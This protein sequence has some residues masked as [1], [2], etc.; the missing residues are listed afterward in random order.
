MASSNRS[1][2]YG[3]LHRALKRAGYEKITTDPELPVIEHVLFAACL[4]N[5]TYDAARGAYAALEF[6]FIDWNEVRV[7]TARELTD[8]LSD[9]PRAEETADR[10]RKVLQ[11]TFESAYSFDLEGMRKMNQGA[12][13]DQL[14]K[15]EGHTPFILSYVTQTALGGHSIPIDDAALSVLAKMGVLT[16]KQVETKKTP[17]L[18]R[19]IP[20]TKG[21]E[22]TGLFHQFTMEFSET[23]YDDRVLKVI[24]SVNA[25]VAKAM[26]KEAAALEVEKEE[27]KKADAAAKR[28]ATREAKKKAAESKALAESPKT[29]EAAPKKPEKKTAKKKVATSTSTKGK[30]APKKAS[31][32]SPKKKT[33]AKT[34]P[35]MPKKSTKKKPV[36]T[37][38]ATTTSK[39]APK[40]TAKK[41][42]AKK[43][44]KK[45]K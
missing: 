41:K 40:K 42:V 38:K 14:K 24:K 12:A 35:A 44:T 29:S 26:V 6:N 31:A 25:G 2:M 27:K 11:S 15:I 20:K 45:K 33:S 9:L 8:I 1:E 16:E 21:V 34:K 43:R 10:I 7:T 4:E 36:T 22:F 32:A 13:V 18:E 30:A 17:G 37:K 19:T 23:P 28:A 5:A 39:A 3:T